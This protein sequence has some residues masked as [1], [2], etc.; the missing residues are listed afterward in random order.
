MTTEI[1]TDCPILITPSAVTEI[2]RL[3]NSNEVLPTQALR[4]GV[5][6]GG[7]S[8]MTYLLEF[9]TIKPND[10]HYDIDGAEIIMEKS[11]IMYV[12][13]MKVDYGDGLNARGF[14][15]TNPNAKE[16]CGCGVSFSS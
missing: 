15:F 12:I 4:I 10:N 14:T 1:L 2:K 9:D 13:G 6:G 16:T 11:H 8:G 5:K 3:K 7:C